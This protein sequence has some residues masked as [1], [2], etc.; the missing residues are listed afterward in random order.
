MNLDL[1]VTQRLLAAL[2]S[3]EKKLRAIHIAGT[4]GKG[5]VSVMVA[6]AL[7]AAGFSVGLYTSPHLIDFGERI[8]VNG[9]PISHPEIISLFERI[10][11]A[12][13]TQNIKVTFFEAVTAMAFVKFAESQVDYAVLE[14]GLGGRLD[15]TNVCSPVVCGI[16]TIDFDHMQYLGDT[17]GKIAKEKA[18]IAK[19]GVPLVCGETK[20]EARIAIANVCAQEGTPLSVINEDFFSVPTKDGVSYQGPKRK[21]EGVSL[22]LLGPHQRHNATVALRILELLDP[23]GENISNEAIR[24]GFASASWPGRLER[25]VGEV[26]VL[27]DG[28][29]NP[30]GAKALREAL[31]ALF[32]DKKIHLVFGASGDKPVSEMLSLLLPRVS[33]FTACQSKRKGALPKEEILQTVARLSPTLPVFSSESVE[34]A[35]Q[36]A[37]TRA[38]PGEVVLVAGSLFVVGE[39]RKALFP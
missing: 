21:I 12:A 13:Q 4:N 31:D 35:L 15:A 3:P 6:S 17:L 36:A 26:T 23:T 9:Q 16:V 25:F 18:G 28:A 1:S 22:S 11:A 38:K 34:E 8:R 10:E 14:V 5:S 30:H 32:L 7:S 20:E 24:K 37:K 19:P 39:A 27:L 29:H 33:S 2:Q